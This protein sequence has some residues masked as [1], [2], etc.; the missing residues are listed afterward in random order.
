MLEQRYSRRGG[1]SSFVALLRRRACEEPQRSAY[2]FLADGDVERGTLTYADVDRR[3]R[4]IAARLQSLGLTGER[5]LLL[6]PPGLD[7][8]CAFFGCLYAGVVAVPA[9]TPRRNRSLERIRS[10][11][12][13]ARA[14]AVLAT[15]LVAA[16]AERLA[17]E[18]PCRQSVRWLLSDE[19][20][21][22]EAD[23]WQEPSHSGESLALLQYTSGSTATPKG[24][25]L[26]HGNLLHN[27]FWIARRYEHTPESKGV[28]WLPPYHDMGLVGGILQ[29]LYAGLHCYL[30]SPATVFS[31]PFAWLQAVSRYRATTSGGP[32][33]AFDLCLRRISAEQRATLDLSC[34][35]VAFCGAE[36]IRVETLERF[37]EMFAPCGFRREAFYPCYGLAEGTVMVSGGRKDLPFRSLSVRKSALEANEIVPCASG[38][39]GSATLV[40]CGHTFDDQQILTVHPERHTRCAPGQVG[41]IWVSGPSI[42]GGYWEKPEENRHTLGAHLA[43]TGEGPF[44]RTGDL[45]FLHEGELFITGRLKDLLILCGRNLYPQDLEHTAERAHAELQPG[46]GAA[47]SMEADRQEK[48]VIAHEV[49]PRRQPDVEEVAE[50]VRQAVLEAYEAE[51]YAFVLLKPGAIPRTSSG[52]IKRRACKSAFLAG[53]LERIGEWRAPAASSGKGVTRAMLFGLRPH[54]RQAWLEGYF[55]NELARR[56]RLDPAAVDSHQPMNMLGLDSLTTVELKNV[57]EGGLGVSLTL[58]SFL[59]GASITQLASE[60]LK[61]LSASAAVPDA[62][63]LSRL[64]QEIQQLSGDQVRKLLDAETIPAGGTLP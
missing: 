52:K 27:C 3:A 23:T 32:N 55:R 43:D 10:I 57:L 11:A 59:Q 21:E 28:I 34:W 56:L 41:E 22:E 44:L 16:T 1:D 61:K 26:T 12:R 6:Y 62:P 24:V 35:Q 37:C 18:A 20:A 46:C 53:T 50:A 38:V 64:L 51:L 31:S 5:A 13:D 29:P 54:E 30:M 2:T 25:M 47:F 39:P 14:S 60:V 19:F 17:E 45:G 63:A 48:L 58:G 9:Y 8:V 49:L 15:R 36:P 33:F 7:Y 42:T 4:A 40:G